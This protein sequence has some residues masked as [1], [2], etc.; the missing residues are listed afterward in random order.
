MREIQQIQ[1]RRAS[2]SSHSAVVKRGG[3]STCYMV[4]MTL[5]LAA[6]GEAPSGVEDAISAIAEAD[7]T[8]DHA[9]G[10]I[11]YSFAGEQL[12]FP[13]MPCRITASIVIVTGQEG[14]TVLNLLH[15]NRPKV[16]YRHHFE[17]DGLRYWD[18][19]DSKRDDIDYSVDGSTVTASGTMRNTNQW[20]ESSNGGWENVSGSYGTPDDQVFAFSVTCN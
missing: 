13:A 2:G 14:E 18:Q 15:D 1:L 17:R 6:C 4:L 11:E 20:R 12:E 10:I 16:E 9:S 3:L 19:W 7:E 8:G 5:V